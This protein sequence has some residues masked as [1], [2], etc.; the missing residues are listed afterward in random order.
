VSE[1]ADIAVNRALIDEL[2]ASSQARFEAQERA[3]NAA[4]AS[5][6]KATTKAEQAAERRFEALN[7]LRSMASDWRAEFARKET[8][9]AQM[10]A[11][12]KESAALQK[13]VTALEQRS[14]G[15]HE[16]W[17]TAGVVIGLLI[18]AIGVVA[19]VLLHH[20]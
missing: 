14:K 16:N 7:E 8:V 3:V 17:G 9:D 13:T 20:G 11:L 12:S 2:K 10:Q 4:L 19:S 5:A 6:E 1:K 15:I 18:A